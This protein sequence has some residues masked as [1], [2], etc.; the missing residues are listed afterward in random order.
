MYGNM[1]VS[2]WRDIGW[3]KVWGLSD[4]GFTRVRKAILDAV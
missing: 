3:K 1:S 2:E 4:I